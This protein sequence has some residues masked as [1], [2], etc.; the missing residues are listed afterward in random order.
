[1]RTGVFKRLMERIRGSLAADP[2]PEQW[3]L[4]SIIP[5][6]KRAYT[7]PYQLR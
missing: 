6:K 4:D 5:K 1:M 3:S 7:C 2:S